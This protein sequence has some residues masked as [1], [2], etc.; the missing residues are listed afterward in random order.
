V[1]NG[2]SESTFVLR[3]QWNVKELWLLL[4]QFYRKW[5]A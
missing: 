1:K 2:K 3:N 4:A 5:A